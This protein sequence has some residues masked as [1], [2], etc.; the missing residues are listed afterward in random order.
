MTAAHVLRAP[1][2]PRSRSI[3]DT[4]DIHSGSTIDLMGERPDPGPIVRA[5]RRRP[6]LDPTLP[7]PAP[8]AALARL[9]LVQRPVGA[10][11]AAAA[12]VAAPK[13]PEATA[14]ET[15]DPSIGLVSG[16][17]ELALGLGATVFALVE[18]AEISIVQIFG[19]S[20]GGAAVS[21][22]AGIFFSLLLAAIAGAINLVALKVTRRPMMLIGTLLAFPI[23]I[24]AFTP[25]QDGL[26]VFGYYIQGGRGVHPTVLR[27]QDPGRFRR[28]GL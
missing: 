12:P 20:F 23:A 16:T 7:G 3:R 18:Y 2:V 4:A 17:V 1:L 24:A 9:Q 28:D 26:T 14:K 5:P 27:Y 6:S 10:P 19:G 15:D 21:L 22:A 13:P 11:L 8:Q 25:V